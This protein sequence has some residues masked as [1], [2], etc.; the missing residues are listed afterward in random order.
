M[1]RA[2]GYPPPAVIVCRTEDYGHVCCIPLGMSEVS[3]ITFDEKMKEKAKVHKG[4]RMGTF[5]YG[6]SSFAIIFERI[7]GKDIIFVNAEGVY[8]E[9][10]PPLP[11]GSAGSGG[12]TTYIGSKIGEWV[13]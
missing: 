7:P 2:V 13:S 3:T 6:G 5:N 11:S 10:D 9:Q 4:Q 1:Y 8:Y 12:E